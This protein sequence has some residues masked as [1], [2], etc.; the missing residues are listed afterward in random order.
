MQLSTPN[1]E[2]LVK[3]VDE[4]VPMTVFDGNVIKENTPKIIKNKINKCNRQLKSF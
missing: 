1:S 3:V 2:H 4:I